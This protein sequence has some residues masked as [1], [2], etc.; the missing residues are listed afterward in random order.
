MRRIG[1]MH[2]AAK[3]LHSLQ[4]DQLLLDVVLLD[5]TSLVGPPRAVVASQESVDGCLFRAG[6]SIRRY[7]IALRRVKRREERNLPTS[8]KIRGPW[9]MDEGLATISESPG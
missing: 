1:S 4:S 6:P 5:L 9:D 8:R 2:H 3:P 7:E